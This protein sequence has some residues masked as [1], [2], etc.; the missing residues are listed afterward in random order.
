VSTWNDFK[1]I[2]GDNNLNNITF[3]VVPNDVSVVVGYQSGNYQAFLQKNT[4]Y[5][6]DISITGSP[7]NYN[8]NVSVRYRKAQNPTFRNYWVVYPLYIDGSGTASLRLG[9]EKALGS[10]VEGVQNNVNYVRVDVALS[11]GIAGVALVAAVAVVAAMVV[12]RKKN[13]SISV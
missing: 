1:I 9:A 2:A 10:N 3:N 4:T 8:L 6:T 11:V 7:G 5:D 12:L 13:E